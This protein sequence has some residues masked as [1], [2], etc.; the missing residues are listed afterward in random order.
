[1]GEACRALAATELDGELEITR[2]VDALARDPRG[3]AAGARVILYY[4][5]GGGLGHLTPRA[6]GARRAR[7]GGDA[8]DRR[9]ASP[10]IRA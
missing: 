7:S 9:R 1:M 5:L 10:A 8:A 4:A 3:A 2:Y 6:Q